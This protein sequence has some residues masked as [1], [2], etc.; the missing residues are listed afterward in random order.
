MTLL[1]ASAATSTQLEG[2]LLAVPA[3]AQGV[4]YAS[5]PGATPVLVDLLVSGPPLSCHTCRWHRKR[6]QC[7]SHAHH[8]DN[9]YH[10]GS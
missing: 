1:F 6:P 9:R 8:L 10:T 5:N 3:G 7:T 2:E 4:V